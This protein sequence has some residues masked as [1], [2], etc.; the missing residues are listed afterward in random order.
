MFPDLVLPSSAIWRDRSGGGTSQ[1]GVRV[2]FP[3]LG[4]RPSSS[5][6]VTG[7]GFSLEKPAV[8][9]PTVLNWTVPM[10][11][12]HEHVQNQALDGNVY[13][14]KFLEKENGQ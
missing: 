13:S 9:I 12:H 6:H 2:N 7:L 8:A 11:P 10:P 1:E 5:S 3:G 4:L 14:C